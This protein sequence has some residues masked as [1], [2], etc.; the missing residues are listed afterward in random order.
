MGDVSTGQMVKEFEDAVFA[1]NPGEIS[2]LVQ[3][4]YGFHIIHS[5]KRETPTLESMR[6]DLTA[7]V[8]LRK[9]QELAK[10]KAEEALQLAKK[11]GDLN[12]TAKEMQNLIGFE[13]L[14]MELR[15]PTC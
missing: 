2:D 13:V 14:K 3:T 5:I 8:R 11:N 6:G 10:Q 9:A 4:Q 15:S 7:S 12:Q 1:L